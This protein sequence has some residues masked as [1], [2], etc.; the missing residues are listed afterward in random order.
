MNWNNGVLE[1]CEG[2]RPDSSIV[3]GGENYAR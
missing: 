2:I 1:Y 3:R